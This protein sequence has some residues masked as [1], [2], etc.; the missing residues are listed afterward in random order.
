[1]VRKNET[2]GNYDFAWG[3]RR[4]Y[5]R[6]TG[7]SY[8]TWGPDNS[9]RATI[10]KWGRSMRAEKPMI[11]IFYYRNTRDEEY[12]KNAIEDIDKKYIEIL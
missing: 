9:E 7:E 2:S 11:Y 8:E 1:M 3:K 6:S 12:L 10:Q 4:V 5:D